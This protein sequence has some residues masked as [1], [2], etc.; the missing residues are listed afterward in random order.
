MSEANRPLV[1]AI[2]ALG[3]WQYTEDDQRTD[4]QAAIDA[5]GH[6]RATTDDLD[7]NWSPDGTY[8]T[9]VREYIE[10]PDCPLSGWHPVGTLAK[11]ADPS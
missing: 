8:V 3:A 11:L 6:L 1:A 5:C 2:Q 7:E 9:G 4:E 10:C